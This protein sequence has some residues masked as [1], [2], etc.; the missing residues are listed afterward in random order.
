MT[1]FS[2]LRIGLLAGSLLGPP[3]LVLAQET[4]R[5]PMPSGTLPSDEVTLELPE[6]EGAR[7]H[8]VVLAADD[9]H[10]RGQLLL[11]TQ[12]SSS[13]PL[14]WHSRHQEQEVQTLELCR[15][16]DRLQL[17]GRTADGHVFAR[18]F[19]RERWL[20]AEPHM[21]CPKPANPR[22]SAARLGAAQRNHFAR[23]RRPLAALGQTL[24]V[25]GTL[26][27]G[28]MDTLVVR[29]ERPDPALTQE[30]RGYSDCAKNASRMSPQRGPSGAF[31]DAL[32]PL[33]HAPRQVRLA[34][35]QHG[36]TRVELRIPGAATQD[37]KL[38]AETSVPG[39]L[40]SVSGRGPTRYL[41]VSAPASGADFEGTIMLHTNLPAAPLV[42]IRV[43]GQT[44]K[45][46]LDT[47]GRTPLA[48]RT[49]AAFRRPTQSPHRT[50]ALDS[51][52]LR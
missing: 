51:P 8:A 40:A 50:A 19:V 42:P 18:D 37:V 47:W 34:L 4:H 32:P 22:P 20:P 26:V 13:A 2:T 31:F 30:L 1:W 39:V 41:L 25:A 14:V 15:Q 16:G 45:D 38:S 43:I 49:T 17:L 33:V 24:H 27:D 6:P 44:S 23:C 52:P 29:G 48:P 9:A 35:G 7:L 46:W 36:S 12:R 10:P 3:G 28:R 11:G 5:L 21:S